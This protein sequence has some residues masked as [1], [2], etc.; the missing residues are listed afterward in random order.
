MSE[1]NSNAGIQMHKSSLTLSVGCFM[2]AGILR[3]GYLALNLGDLAVLNNRQ[4]T[5]VARFSSSS[6]LRPGAFVELAGVRIG[7]VSSI[8]LDHETYESKVAMRIEPDVHLQR[9]AIASIRTAGI[10]GE[11]FVKISPGGAED[12]LQPGDEITETESSISI[13]ELIS[14][15]IFEGSGKTAK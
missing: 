13:E 7:K 2:V 6:G 5:L 14:K 4:Y 10:I 3:L 9:D 15:Y 1:S 11:K 8:L 12:F